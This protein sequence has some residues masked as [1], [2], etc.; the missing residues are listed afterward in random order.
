[1]ERQV[2]ESVLFTSRFRECAARSLFM[3]RSDPGRRVPLWQQRLR[4]AQLLQSARTVKNF[5]LLLETA[6]ECL[7]DVY[8]MPALNEVM[9]GLH[10][11]TIALK[12]VETESPSPFAENILF[13][14]VGTVMYQYDQPQAERSTQLL[15]LDSQML[16][17]LLGTTDMA[18]VLNPDV[19]REVEQE[20]EK[21]T[22]WNEL[23]ADDVT[24]RV[25]R[26]AKTHGP[27]TADQIIAYLHLDAAS[28]VH[29]LDEL[30]AKGDLLQGHFVDSTSCSRW[31]ELDAKRTEG[32][33]YPEKGHPQSTPSTAPAGGSE[34]QWLHKDVFRRIRS[35][36]LDKARKAVRPVEPEAFQMFLIDRQGIGPVGGERYEGADGLMRVIEQLEGVALPAGLWETAIFPA[37]VRDYQPSAGRTRRNWIH[38]QT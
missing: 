29:A 30:A 32:G 9:T 23:A 4:G 17:R 34:Q 28:V 31:R 1:M 21:R 14:F 20:L 6:R 27:F 22:F 25:T 5:P 33:P 2:G 7:Q 19:I 18:K 24:G 26:Y 38:D 3:P 8:D 10:S 11:G 36:S 15:S 13:G 16:E 12:D 37:R 35:R